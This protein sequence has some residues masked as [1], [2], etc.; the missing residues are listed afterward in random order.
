MLMGSLENGTTGLLLD[1]MWRVRK[2]R[3]NVVSTVIGRCVK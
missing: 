2:K 1:L 3:L